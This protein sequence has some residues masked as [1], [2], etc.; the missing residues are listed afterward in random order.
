MHGT[1][2]YSKYETYV[3][4]NNGLCWLLDKNQLVD[5]PQG[6]FSIP[7]LMQL[8]LDNN[9][10]TEIP[11]GIVSTK[12]EMS[13]LFLS[14]NR[15]KNIPYRAFYNVHKQSSDQIMLNLNQQQGIFD[16]GKALPQIYRERVLDLHHQG[17]S[18]REISENV[19]VS[20]G[21]VNNV[22]RLYEDC[23]TSLARQRRTPARNKVT[24]Y[25]AEYIESEKLCRPSTYTSEI[26]QRLLLDGVSPPGHL[27]SLSAIKK[28]VRDD[29]RMTKKKISQVPAESLTQANM[30]YTD[31]FLDQVSHYNYTQLHFFDEASVIVTSGNR[32]YGN[33]PIGEPAFEFQ[34]YASNANY[35]LN[36]LH[37][38]Q[39]VD[40]FDIL[41]G[42]SNGMELLNFFNE[43]LTIDRV[44]GS[45]ILENGDL[46]VMDNCGFH[47]GHFVEPLLRNILQDYGVELLFQP[48]Y[49]P[50]LNTCEMC[51][52]QVKCFL[53]KNTS[54]TENETQIAIGEGVAKITVVNSIGY[55]RQCGYID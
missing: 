29:C 14:G 11:Q 24:P 1:R 19:R 41:H 3:S 55:F 34:R 32:L 4:D 49:S 47:H 33:S 52:N 21:Y 40:Y 48:A 35:T 2:R 42:A 45:A 18:Q 28:C 53:R 17:F 31:Y 39:G 51:F 44:D 20:V 46:V 27:P 13:F 54:L 50:H 36:L 7:L 37:S 8:N 16:N 30:D 26:Q 6:V 22:V 38:I 5:V 15:L 25:V 43:A 9:Q 10:M 23:N 12:T